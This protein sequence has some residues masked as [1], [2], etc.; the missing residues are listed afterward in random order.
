MA[1]FVDDNIPTSPVI[2]V[3]FSKLQTTAAKAE[4]FGPETSALLNLHLED[5]AF[6][7]QVAEVENWWSSPRF[8]IVQRPYTAEQICGARG[9]L[10]VPYASDA[11]SKKL[12]SIIEKRAKVSCIHLVL[13]ALTGGLPSHSPTQ[14]RR[15]SF[16]THILGRQVQPLG[17]WTLSRSHRWHSTSTQSTYPAGS[18]LP[19]PRHRTSHLQT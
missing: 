13:V 4:D 18:A 2:S 9:S 19:P 12:W 5:M 11:L 14:D 7:S 15:S 10:M 3:D 1:P 17:V 8:A 6:S 16:Q